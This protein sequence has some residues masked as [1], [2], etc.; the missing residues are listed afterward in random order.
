MDESRE[1][2]ITKLL[3]SVQSDHPRTAGPST[4][5]GHWYAH[6]FFLLLLVQHIPMPVVC[7]CSYFD[8]EEP[9]ED[10]KF[11]DEED[12]NNISQKKS[13]RCEKNNATL[14]GG[15]CSATIAG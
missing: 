15:G 9:E 1:Q 12:D 3:H 10:I 6:C 14:R 8:G 13:G 11:E 2:H 4:N 5:T 7:F